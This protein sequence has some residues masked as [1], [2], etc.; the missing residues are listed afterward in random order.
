MPTRATDGPAQGFG[1][2][3][4]TVAEHASAIVRLEIELA[5]ME[6]KRKVIA[7][8]LGIALALT[9]AVLLL[10]VLGFAFASLAAGFATF[11]ATWLA[12]LIVAAIL[13]AVA[14]LLLVLAIGRFKQGTPPVPEQAIREA[15]LTAEALK[16]DGSG[17]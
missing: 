8:G 12:L 11:L 1:S 5:T 2:A 3:A 9:A 4:K 13:F 15:K 16:S 10:F 7:L 14:G 17:A 6:L